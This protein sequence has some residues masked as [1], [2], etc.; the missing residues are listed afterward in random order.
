MTAITKKIVQE[1]LQVILVPIARF[2][3]RNA[4]PLKD[5]TEI[6]KKALI[7]AAVSEL[8]NT[9]QPIS[10][11]KIHVMSGV[12]RLEVNRIYVKG[13]EKDTDTNVVSRVIA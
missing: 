8:R 3:V 11:S 9:G 1:C 7:Q 6:M 10:V 2:C 5:L 4:L 13:E 12:P